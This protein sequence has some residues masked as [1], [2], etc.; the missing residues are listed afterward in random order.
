MSA[1]EYAATIRHPLLVPTTA[2]AG[3]QAGKGAPDTPTPDTPTPDTPTRQ[4]G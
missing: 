1:S 4:A 3:R 2:T